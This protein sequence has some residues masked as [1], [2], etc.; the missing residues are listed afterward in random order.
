MH[1]DEDISLEE[2]R[3]TMPKY[4]SYASN[5]NYMPQQQNNMQSNMQ[6]GMQNNM[7]NNMPM[8]M[9]NQ[10][11]GMGMRPNMGQQGM[12]QQ[13]MMGMPNQGM[14]NMGYQGN[15]NYNRPPMQ[16]GRYWMPHSDW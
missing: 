12:G 10:G 13:G 6:Q 16:Q 4:S 5:K 1:P 11:P 2:K 9:G 14:Y 15:N 7:Q 3:A 8:G